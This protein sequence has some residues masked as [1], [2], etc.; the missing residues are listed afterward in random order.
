MPAR[1]DVLRHILEVILVPGIYYVTLG[2]NQA[3][4]HLLDHLN[5]VASFRV[6]E[7]DVFGPRRFPERMTGSVF[8]RSEWRFDCF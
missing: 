4:G 8:A 5:R 7:A 6:V 3:N 1:G 2:M